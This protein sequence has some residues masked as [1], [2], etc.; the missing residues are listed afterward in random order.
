MLPKIESTPSPV[1]VPSSVGRTSLT[2]FV[3]SFI[4]RLVMLKCTASLLQAFME[5]PVH[6]LRVASRCSNDTP[7]QANLIT[8]DL[9][10]PYYLKVVPVHPA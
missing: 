3:Q 6:Q 10:S 7:L 9:V 8:S 1:V 2:K 5:F 4:K